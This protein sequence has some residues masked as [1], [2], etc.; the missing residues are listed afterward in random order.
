MREIPVCVDLMQL[1]SES[2]PHG[3]LGL[4]FMVPSQCPISLESAH[5]EFMTM[6]YNTGIPPVGKSPLGARPELS[7]IE[8]SG[9]TVQPNKNATPIHNAM[10]ISPRAVI[11]TNFLGNKVL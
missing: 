10:K 1:P 9:T 4:S 3:P 8:S 6:R 5:F 2:K 11:L 7:E